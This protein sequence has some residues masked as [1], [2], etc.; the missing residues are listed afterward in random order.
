MVG[1]STTSKLVGW[2]NK[3][4]NSISSP[5]QGWDM[6]DAKAKEDG[7]SFSSFFRIKTN[8]ITDERGGE[9]ITNVKGERIE[10]DILLKAINGKQALSPL[11]SAMNNF[12]RQ[13]VDT[14]KSD[15][16]DVL[17]G[18]ERLDGDIIDN[19]IKGARSRGTGLLGINLQDSDAFI[20]KV[21]SCGGVE[22]SWGNIASNLLRYSLECKSP[23]KSYGYIENQPLKNC[24]TLISEYLLKTEQIDNIDEVHVL[25]TPLVTPILSIIQY[26]LAEYYTNA[27]KKFI[28]NPKENKK[29]NAV[30]EDK[31]SENQ[32]KEPDTV[33]VFNPKGGFA[34]HVDRSTSEGQARLNE[35]LSQGYTIMES[36]KINIKLQK[37]QGSI[38]VLSLQSNYSPTET[39]DDLEDA[40]YQD[41][42]I[43]TLTEEPQSFSISVDDDGYDIEQCA[44]CEIDPCDSL[45]SVMNVAIVM[46]RNLYILHWMAKGNDMMKLHVL[47]EDLYSELIQEIDTLGELLVE[48]C[49]TVQNLDF[50]WTPIAVRNY[51]FQE[52]LIILKDFIQNYIDT[53]D[54]AYPNQTSDVQSTLDEWLRY[55]NKQLNYFVKGQEI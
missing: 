42:F 18:K 19:T 7:D 39:L 3:T 35:L 29:D 25:V 32:D 48:K 41:E 43:D 28:S 27:Y 10:L 13:D 53:I 22:W 1:S 20:T 8:S 49:G 46:Y 38:D 30:E 11:F 5:M 21:G 55:W 15:I 50:E 54:Y 2:L 36:K 40:I 37:I 33:A 51:E 34:E 31:E 24:S 26:K 4:L 52:S 12:S 17:L 16:L 6:E 45:N 9:A 23:G 47:T 44:E 14:E